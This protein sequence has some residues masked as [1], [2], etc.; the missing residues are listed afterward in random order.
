MHFAHNGLVKSSNLFGLN[1]FIY[2]FYLL[3][4]YRLL[5]LWWVTK[6]GPGFRARV[7][8][9]SWATKNQSKAIYHFFC[10]GSLLRP[11][12]KSLC[13]PPCSPLA[14]HATV[15]EPS[16]WLRMRAASSLIEC[17]GASYTALWAAGALKDKKK[18]N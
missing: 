8:Y 16:P 17:W 1:F 2:S 7:P 5:F 15:C 12:P 14:D 9:S 18:Y 3:F 11:L 6:K 13:Y 4:Y 10:F